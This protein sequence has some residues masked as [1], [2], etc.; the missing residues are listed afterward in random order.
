MASDSD[1]TGAVGACSNCHTKFFK[2]DHRG[3]G[4]R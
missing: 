3:G 1:D 4:G 2:L